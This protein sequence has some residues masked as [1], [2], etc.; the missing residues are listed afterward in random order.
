MMWIFLHLVGIKKASLPF[1]LF[2]HVKVSM[3]KI[4]DEKRQIKNMKKDKELKQQQQQNLCVSQ[5]R[6]LLQQFI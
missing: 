2:L 6:Y 1:Y 3:R 5:R 4:L